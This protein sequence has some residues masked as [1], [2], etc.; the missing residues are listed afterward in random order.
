VDLTKILPRDRI[1]SLGIHKEIYCYE[2]H[3]NKGNTYELGYSNIEAV[4][5][6]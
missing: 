4:K 2:L 5:E 6:G 3:K 1:N